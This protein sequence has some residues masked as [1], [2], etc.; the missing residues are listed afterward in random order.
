LQDTVGAQPFLGE[1]GRD[2]LTSE[3]KSAVLRSPLRAGSL[4]YRAWEDA[5]A[6]ARSSVATTR[7]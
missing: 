4:L 7:S 1:Q 6:I 5:A 2:R 3:L